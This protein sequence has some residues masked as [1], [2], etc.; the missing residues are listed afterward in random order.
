MAY[1][2]GATATIRVQMTGLRSVQS[3]ITGL[4]NRIGKL[5]A[6]TSAWAGETEK[7]TQ[8][9]FLFNQMLF[10]MHRYAYNTT[11]GLT[12]MGGAAIVM[13]LKFNAAMEMNT[14]AFTQFLGSTKLANKELDYLYDLAKTTPFEFANVTDAARRFLAFGFTLR[15]TN[16][17]LRTIGDTVAAF[18]GGNEQI[19]R[20]VT[21]FGQAHA[22]GRILGQDMLQLEQ[23]GVPVLDILYKQLNKM[24]Y[25]VSRKQLAKVGELGLP[26]D[27]G[28]PA[29]MRGMN[30]MFGGMSAKQAQTALG[31][32]STLHDA[33]TQVM[34][35]LTL[36]TFKKASR[37]LLPSINKMFGEMG[38]LAR[39]QGNRISLGQVLGIAQ[40]DYPWLRP[41]LDLIRLLTDAIRPLWN[42]IKNGL[43]P[44][45]V[46]MGQV[47][48]RTVIPPLRLAL[49]FLGWLTQSSIIAIPIIWGLVGAWIAEK[50][51]LKAV[52]FW[53][54]ANAA[55]TK[56]LAYWENILLRWWYLN[57]AIGR[58]Y[59]YMLKGQFIA[60][61]RLVTATVLSAIAMWLERHEIRNTTTAMKALGR[62]T[63]AAAR[64][65]RVLLA[66]IWALI[67]ENPI[68]AIVTAILLVIFSLVILYFKWKWFH[69][70]VNRTANYIWHHWLL[71]LA[72]INLILPGLGLIIA[73]IVIITKKWGLV[74]AAVN[75]VW[76]LLKKAYRWI[77]DHW[78]MALAVSL[79]TPFA[80]VAVA[81]AGIIFWIKGMIE[82][83]KEAVKWAKKLWS[84]V[85]RAAGPLKWMWRKSAGFRGG[86]VDAVSA[87]DR[88][89]TPTALQPT[90]SGA[91]GTG[92]QD[93]IGGSVKRGERAGKGAHFTS[94]TNILLDGKKV[95]EATSRHRQDKAARR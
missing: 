77:M 57:E 8:R 29:L 23:Q 85:D 12:A 90:T 17:Y 91:V 73:A 83:F 3:G 69:N 20:M 51:I 93:Q 58:A 36:T 82:M 7:A 72:I 79:V 60:K 25:A 9:G 10:T 49:R 89:V 26:S 53:K 34:G 6:Q 39:K 37:G 14:V 28:I 64:A 44:I 54:A 38:D 86:V 50:T 56:L 61:M 46:L 71:F 68:G 27:I 66:S 19:E 21:V 18:G 65:T 16:K 31:Q 75:Y 40:K 4:S 30:E 84:W 22:S 13:G 88:L 48:S 92:T 52:A 59:N 87:V 11:L 81:I 42:L 74:T 70:L 80:P 2:P 63:L 95:A 78:V 55:V 67:L 45:L 43:L 35:G 5:K 33:I 76:N 15:D 32:L 62:A 41:F 94:T 47:V 1:N 24:G